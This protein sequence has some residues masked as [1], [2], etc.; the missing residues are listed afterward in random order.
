MKLSDDVP[1]G[2]ET[3]FSRCP[4]RSILLKS[5]WRREPKAATGASSG[6]VSLIM[7]PGLPT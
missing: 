5:T 4:L 3:S 2:R 6:Q 1:F 7:R